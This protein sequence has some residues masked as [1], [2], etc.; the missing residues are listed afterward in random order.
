[1]SCA[2]SSDPARGRDRDAVRATL[3]NRADDLGRETIQKSLKSYLSRLRAWL[4][5]ACSGLFHGG[6]LSATP[7][8]ALMF[9]AI[10]RNGNSASKY[11]DA[12]KWIYVYL[13]R[14]LTWMSDKVRQTLRGAKKQTRVQNALKPRRAIRWDLLCRLVAYAWR[15]GDFYYA[16]AYVMAANFLLRCRDELIGMFFE[17]LSFNLQITPCTVSLRLDSR[18]NMP[19]GTS[20]KRRCICQSHPWLCPVHMTSRLCEKVGRQ[21]KGKIFPFS[22]SSLQNVL[23]AHLSALGEPNAQEYS[24][25]AFRRGTARE[26]VA[27]QSSLA[28]VLAAGQW[29]SAAFLLYI[30]KMDVEE[31]AV[32][33]ALDSLSDDD[34]AGHPDSAHIAVPSTSAKAP[35]TQTCGR[36]DGPVSG[37]AIPDRRAHAPP[38]AQQPQVAAALPSTPPA[39]E[40]AQ[41][42]TSESHPRSDTAQSNVAGTLVPAARHAPS[43]H[44]AIPKKRP[45]KRGIR[46]TNT[47]QRRSA[48]NA[49]VVPEALAPI[50]ESDDESDQDY[51]DLPFIND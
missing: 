30:D 26:M 42:H 3:L 22:Y 33:A 43:G 39:P 25:K 51:K 27:S 13:G 23:R 45:S 44:G 1:M 38:R 10:F 17:Q 46:F 18:K 31:D 4:A 2:W 50:G 5:F 15:V 20:M 48:P 32:F 7:A 49:P 47:K 35:V 37:L 34:D 28:E 29:R 12:V 11:L 19:Q 40:E 8:D 9:L 36:P 16:F 6:V 41:T 14:P 21:M 24:T